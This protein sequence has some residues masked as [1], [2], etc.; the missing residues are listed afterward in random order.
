MA[1]SAVGKRRGIDT[2]VTRDK[3]L[4]AAEELIL[5]GGFTQ[6]TVTELAEKADVSRATVFSRFGSKLG[7]LEALS[8]RCAGGPQMRA[9]RQALA[10]PDPVDAVLGTIAASCDH[11]ELQGH[12][13]LTMKA[14]SELEPGAIQLID[15]QRRDQSDSMK[16]LA[17]RLERAG[18]LRGLWR[19]QAAAS[20]H[21]I[22][23]VESFMELRRNWGLSL[24]ATKEVLRS[25]AEGLFD[26]EP[27]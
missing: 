15:D 20:L 23:S 4:E 6:A 19:A 16:H 21:M 25:M 2:S 1:I 3:V 14:V 27:R 11:W 7:V 18:R 12:I 22:T 9:I 24:A 10:L 5:A 8:V 17:R 13:L 26:L